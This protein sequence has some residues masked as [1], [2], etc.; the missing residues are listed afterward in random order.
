MK[1]LFWLIL[2]SF[3]LF[4]FLNLGEFNF[5]PPAE[6]APKVEGILYFRYFSLD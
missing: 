2:T 3:V 1:A 5:D 6:A 4:F